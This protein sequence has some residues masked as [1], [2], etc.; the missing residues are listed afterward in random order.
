MGDNNPGSLRRA[1]WASTQPSLQAPPTAAAPPPGGRSSGASSTVMM[2]MMMMLM[3][4]KMATTSG[5]DGRRAGWRWRAASERVRPV[6][7][8]EPHSGGDGGGAPTVGRLPPSR[9]RPRRGAETGRGWETRPSASTRRPPR[10]VGK[11]YPMYTATCAR[12]T[13]A[14]VLPG[15]ACSGP[16]C[17]YRK[18]LRVGTILQLSYL[19]DHLGLPNLAQAGPPERIYVCRGRL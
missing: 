12:W 17:A 3:M 2:M 10:T 16:A 9:S 14:S 5:E 19:G 7:R 13:L 4:V 18:F 15:P 6:G 8:P 11:E 1:V